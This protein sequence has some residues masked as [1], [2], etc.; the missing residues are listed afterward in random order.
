[1]KATAVI[2][3]VF[4]KTMTYHKSHVMQR[5]GIRATAE[6]MKYALEHGITGS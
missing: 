1:M 6:L 3:R 2:A 4:G 5:L